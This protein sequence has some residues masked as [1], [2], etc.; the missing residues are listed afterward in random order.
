MDVKKT[1]QNYCI[2]KNRRM[3]ISCKKMEISMIKLLSSIIIVFFSLSTFAQS[4][5]ENSHCA[6]KAAQIITNK[7]N[8]RGEK[9]TLIK[10][11]PTVSKSSYYE[12][13]HVYVNVQPPYNYQFKQVCEIF[14]RKSNCSYGGYYSCGRNLAELKNH[15]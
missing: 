4:S 5:L 9:A 2:L 13:F 7:G 12:G 6:S 10:I 15:F 1:V 14:L 8:Y 11:L 3:S